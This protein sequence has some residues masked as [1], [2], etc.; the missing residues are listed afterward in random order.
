MKEEEEDHYF[1]QNIDYV[2][3]R[4]DSERHRADIVKTSSDKQRKGKKTKRERRN[5]F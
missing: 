4:F 2:S 1:N 3:P 5:L